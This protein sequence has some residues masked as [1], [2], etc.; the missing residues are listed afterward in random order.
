MALTGWITALAKGIR[1]RST[2][3]RFSQFGSQYLPVPPPGEQQAIVKYVRH[4]QQKA[5]EAI[6]AKRQLVSRLTEQK[7][8]TVHQTVTRGMD[9]SVGLKMSGS[10]WI[11]TIPTHWEMVPIKRLLE[12]S[13]YGTS[14]SPEGHGPIRILTMGNIRSG[15]VHV[16]ETGNSRRVPTGLTLQHNDLLFNRTNSPELVGKVGIYNGPNDATISFASY[17]VRLR[18]RSDYCPEWLNYVLNSPAFWAYARGHALLSLHQANLNPTRYGQLAIPL[19][20][21]GER[22]EIA[23]Y[24]HKFESEIDSAVERAEC[25]IALLREYQNRLTADVVTGKLDVR[26]AAAA[27]PEVDLLDPNVVAAHEASEDVMN[28]DLVGDEATEE[29]M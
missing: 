1:E 12:D 25:E 5:G 11:A 19:P 29:S 17:L 28:S 27:L 10:A 18:T 15:K 13:E 2:D 22:E 21:K 4:I 23:Q 24:L 9:P 6:R 8:V 14:Q 3:F 7:H 20:P 16:P 26:A